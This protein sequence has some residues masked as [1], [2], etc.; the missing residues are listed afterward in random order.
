M[1]VYT[2]LL[3]RVDVVDAGELSGDS[4]KHL[5]IFYT[6]LYRALTFPRRIGEGVIG[7]AR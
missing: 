4:A 6:G 5:T 7:S 2:R 3:K 1:N